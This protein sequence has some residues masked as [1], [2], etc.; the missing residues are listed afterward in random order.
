MIVVNRKGQIKFK[1]SGQKDSKIF[2]P[3]FFKTT[4]SNDG[5]II[6]VETG[7]EYSWGNNVYSVT[8]KG[9]A[10]IG[11][12]DLAIYNKTKT[13]LSIVPI[14]TIKTDGLIIEFYFKDNVVLYEPR[15]SVETGN[16]E[17]DHGG[18]FLY[19]YYIATGKMILTMM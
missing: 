9:I 8:N 10:D 1:S 4:D 15:H 14:T 12:L 5:M 11:K 3:I 2:R 19:T 18:G 6:L 17:F 16:I 13:A 7:G